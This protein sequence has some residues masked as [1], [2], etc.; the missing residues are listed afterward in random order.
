MNKKNVAYIVEWFFP[1]IGGAGV[2]ALNQARMLHDNFNI[3]F[4]TKHPP[5]KAGKITD[6]GFP[7]FRFGNGKTSRKNDYVSAFKLF[8]NLLNNRDQIDLVHIHG[9]IENNFSIAAVLFA[10][11]CGK[12]VI[13][14]LAIKGEF[15]QHVESGNYSL[16]KKINPLNWFRQFT[17]KKLDGYIAISK[18]IENELL[19]A[20]I[21]KNK[22]HF[23]PNGVDTN[24]FKPV[25]KE[26]KK[27]LRQKMNISDDV[28]VFLVVSR[29]AKHKGILNP[30]LITWNDHFKEDIDKLLLIVGSGEGLLS[31]YEQDVYNFVKDNHIT[32]VRLEGRQTNIVSYY[33]VSDIFILPSENEGLSNALLEAVACGLFSIV[34]E[35]ASS[36]VIVNNQNGYIL[37]QLNSDDLYNAITNIQF[38]KLIPN[39]LEP[40]YSLEMTQK[41]L[42]SL[43]FNLFER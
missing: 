25:T 24:R 39:S 16:I 12:V 17:A 29:L 1:V 27:Q 7:V 42:I 40:H 22:I 8:V 43:Y 15:S 11:L 6:V 9:N 18:D 21:Q 4:Y 14:K 31:S 10:K 26:E 37:K 5:K 38:K 33:S 32:N 35:A 30:L 20:G 3:S 2:Q 41:K 19:Q 28:T 36:D 34:S 13:G 23:I